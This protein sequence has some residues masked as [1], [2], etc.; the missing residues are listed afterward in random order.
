MTVEEA[1]QKAN[2]GDVETMVILGD[3]YGQN[4]DYENALV[5]YRK[6]AE[7]GNLDSMYKASLI[8]GMFPVSYTHLTLPTNSL[9]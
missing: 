1:I 7:L 9:V 2:A 5:W 8:D 3:Y 6:A 4:E